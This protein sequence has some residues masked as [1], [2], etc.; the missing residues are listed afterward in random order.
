M[1]KDYYGI[2]GVSQTATADE[3]KAAYRK[4]ALKYHPDRNPNN[5]E[6]EEKF[7]AAAEAYQVLSDPEKRKRYDQ[8]GDA[9]M[10]GFGNAHG[11]NMEDIFSNFG[12]I[13]ETIFGGS[14]HSRRRSTASGPEPRRGHDLQKQITITLKEVFLG[15]KKELSYYRFVGCTTCKGS[16]A[17]P[18]TKVVTC[19]SCQG[20]GQQYTRQGF[21]TYQHTCSTCG[22]QGFIIPSPCTKCKGKTRIQELDTFTVNIPKGMLD[23]KDLRVANKG[24]AGIFGGPAGDL[25]VRVEVKEDPHFKREGNDLRCTVMLTYPQLVFG[26]QVEIENIDGTK[27]TIKIPK[28]CPV[29]ET[30]TLAGKGFPI[31]QGKGRG[32]LIITTQCHIP[33][34]LSTKATDLLEEYSQEIGTSID[35]TDGAIKGFFKKFLG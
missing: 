34:K 17:Q 4:L 12:D 28:G 18:G 19:T 24:D 35:H 11:M 30:I 16:G 10:G 15:T 14:G 33:T 27:E 6:A 31:L 3:I 25:F 7:K 22:G 21:F 2:L 13:F 1:K 9:D 8:F 23:G 32:S 20:S 29:G 5:K 26:A